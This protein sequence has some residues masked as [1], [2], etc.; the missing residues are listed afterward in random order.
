MGTKVINLAKN[1]GI[2]GVFRLDI[3]FDGHI[4]EFTGIKDIATF[5]ALN[6]FYVFFAGHYPHTRMPTGFSHI[7]CFGGTFRGW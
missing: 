7:L 5:L 2:S 6:E 4:L 3:V 1:M